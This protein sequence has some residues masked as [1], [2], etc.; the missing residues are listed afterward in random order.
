MY[1]T[2]VRHSSTI[3]TL[4]HWTT[5]LLEYLSHQSQDWKLYLFVLFSFILAFPAIC[6]LLALFL[7]HVFG[8]LLQRYVKRI[9]WFSKNH[10]LSFCH[11]RDLQF[12]YSTDII[13][14]KTANLNSF[15]AIWHMSASKNKCQSADSVQL[16]DIF[17]S[18]LK[19]TKLKKIKCTRLNWRI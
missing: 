19:M 18:A 12:A 14:Y 6:L 5:D 10:N 16:N 11:F 9:L 4:V 3:I 13:Y 17:S 7:S 1:F 15:V 2:L 8:Q